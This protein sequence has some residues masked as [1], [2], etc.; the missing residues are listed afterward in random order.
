MNRS[1]DTVAEAGETEAG[2]AEEVTNLGIRKSNT[3]QKKLT[4]I[5]RRANGMQ[6]PS[7]IKT[8][9]EGITRTTQI[10]RG[11]AN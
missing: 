4:Q 10:T 11:E 8:S 7:S 3:S 9:L 1:M 2:E 5:M 6:R